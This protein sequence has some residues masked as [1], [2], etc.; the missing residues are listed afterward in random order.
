VH[1]SAA[2]DTLQIVLLKALRG[3][4]AN[5]YFVGMETRRALMDFAMQFLKNPLTPTVVAGHFGMASST[6]LQLSEEMRGQCHVG[7][8]QHCDQNMHLLGA[9]TQACEHHM[10]EAGEPTRMMLWQFTMDCWRF[11]VGG[12]QSGG[13]HL[14]QQTSGG[15]HPAGRDRAHPT[16][17]GAHSVGP[18]QAHPT[19][20]GSHPTGRDRVDREPP[21]KKVR[22]EGHTQ[23]CLAL[24]EN[25]NKIKPETLAEALYHPIQKVYCLSDGTKMW[26]PIDVKES[27]SN[28]ADGLV[29]L[30][31]ARQRAHQDL[32][33]GKTLSSAQFDVALEH[34]KDLFFNNF[35]ENHN[36]KHRICQ[37]KEDPSRITRQNKKKTKEDQRGAFKTW[38]TRIFG[39][40][41][42]FRIVLR[43][44]L[45]DPAEHA[46]IAKALLEDK[47]QSPAH[48]GDAEISKEARITMRAFTDGILQDYFAEPKSTAASSGMS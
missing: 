26:K 47:S 6:L 24:L 4:P 35:L 12:S 11:T 1:N 9:S 22:L 48:S 44:G 17:D 21:S 31:D 28:L 2:G 25:I 34:L 32:D 20:G 19:S 43:H 41:D 38:V 5:G 13:R 45:F 39:S 33:H 27:M 8:H 7:I 14:A 42:F 30:Q 29:L 37:L 36:L 46:K 15:L 16:S 10:V 23:V 40:M 18:D 3:K